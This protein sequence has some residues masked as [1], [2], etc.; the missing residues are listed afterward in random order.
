MKW[1]IKLVYLDQ[2][3]DRPSSN[4][5][6]HPKNFKSKSHDFSTKHHSWRS[7]LTGSHQQNNWPEREATFSLESVSVGLLCS[8]RFSIRSWWYLPTS[9]KWQRIQNTAFLTRNHATKGIVCEKCIKT[10]GDILLS[11]TASSRF[12]CTHTWVCVSERMCDVGSSGQQATSFPQDT[13]WANSAR[14]WWRLEGFS[15]GGD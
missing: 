5:L 15:S 4:I 1:W 2:T 14:R 6:P 11:S 12:S 10:I 3:G 8:Y 7:A 13:C 9:N